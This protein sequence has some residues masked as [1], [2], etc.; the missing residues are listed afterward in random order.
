MSI[1]SSKG[2]SGNR[3]VNFSAVDG[4][5]GYQ[6]GDAVNAT[7]DK[8]SGMLIIR[9]RV[10]QR[11]EVR[12]PLDRITY[13]ESKTETEIR[14]HDK[15]VIGRAAVGSLL[16]GPLGAIVGGMSGIGSKK[17]KSV[18][19]FLIIAYM[20]TDGEEKA[21]ALEIVGASI[22]WHEFLKEI[23]PKFATAPESSVLL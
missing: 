7:I 9:A 8:K 20:S 11:P 15:S 17:S 23:N 19:Q 5:P 6:Q 18:R 3:S 13:A 12:L 1:F 10:F 2:K 22:G 4:L 14:E 21:I 16:L